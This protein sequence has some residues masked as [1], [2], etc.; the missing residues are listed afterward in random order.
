MIQSNHI[1][2]LL[3][4]VINFLDPKPNRNFIDCTLGLG[5]HAKGIL[6]RTAPRGE[7]LAIEMDDESL[8]LA[9]R[10]LKDFKDRVF[11]VQ[12]SF[13]DIQ[14]IA[15]S[16][17]FLDVWGILFDLGISSFQLNNPKR[18]FSFS[19]DGPLDMR[20]N[21][22]LELTAADIVNK[23][24]EEELVLIFQNYGEEKFSRMIA[25]QI[26]QARTKKPITRTLELAQIVLTAI[27]PKARYQRRIHPATRVF[28]ALRIVVNRELENL[29]EALPQAVDILN[30]EGR[31][32]VISFH[33]LEDR[34]VKNYFREQAQLGNLEILTKKPI[35]PT[36]SEVQRNPRSRS[37]KLRVAQKIKN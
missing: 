35:I 20:M 34:I 6:E 19:Q 1:P 31:I 5:N 4:E 7:L 12:G 28:Q 33:S 25:Y 10:E 2:V 24:S 8:V 16:H 14:E 36:P 11:F 26:I 15:Y 3:K 30:P 22:N 29:K 17:H 9:Q 13:A 32:A 18:G 21:K 23:F 27:P 37:A